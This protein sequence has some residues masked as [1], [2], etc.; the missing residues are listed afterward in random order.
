MLKI[1]AVFVLIWI[2]IKA[3]GQVLK[4]FIGGT[5]VNQQRRSPNHQA[6]RQGDIHI[7]HNPKKGNKG[8][9]GGEYVDYEEVE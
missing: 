8:Y 7:D 6:N 9:D 4:V 3:V 5:N 1:L 2:F